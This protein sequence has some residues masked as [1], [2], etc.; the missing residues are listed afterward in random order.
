MNKPDISGIAPFFIVRSVPAALSFYRDRL[1]FDITFQGPDPDD[2]FDDGAQSSQ[3]KTTEDADVVHGRFLEL[4]PNQKI[5]QSVQFDSDDPRFAGEMVMTWL[6]T[7]APEGTTVR[8]T[9]ENVPVGISPADHAA[10]ITA[11]L[12]NLAAFVEG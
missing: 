3:G 8:I 9:A 1:G 12:A 4:V 7:P 10:G 2:I 11:T 6:L 5:V